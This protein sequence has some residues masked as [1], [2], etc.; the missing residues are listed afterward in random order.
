MTSVHKFGKS[1]KQTRAIGIHNRLGDVH[2]DSTVYRAADK[3]YFNM[4]MAFFRRRE[5]RNQ[6]NL[7]RNTNQI[8]S[9]RGLC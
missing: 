1:R 8:C 5:Y 4:A 3:E 9:V 6:S 7:P 2:A